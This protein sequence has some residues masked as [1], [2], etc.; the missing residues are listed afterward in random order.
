MALRYC[1]NNPILEDLTHDIVAIEW[2]TLEHGVIEKK[3]YAK[4]EPETEPEE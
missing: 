1:L 2:G 4:P 3:V